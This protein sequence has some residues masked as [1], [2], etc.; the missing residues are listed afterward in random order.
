MAETAGAVDYL[1]KNKINLF[2][3][4]KTI[5]GVLNNTATTLFAANAVGRY[6]VIVYITSGDAVS[7]TASATLSSF[8]KY[9]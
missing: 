1:V 2:H 9:A 8:I 6:D 7:F 5:A 4:Q 3:L